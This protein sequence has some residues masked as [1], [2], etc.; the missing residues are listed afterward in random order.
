MA[1]AMLRGERTYKAIGILLETNCTDEIG[2]LI[3]GPLG[4]D[5]LWEAVGTAAVAVGGGSVLSR[6][7]ELRIYRR[8]LG[9][10]DG[11]VVAHA[12]L[13]LVVGVGLGVSCAT[14]EAHHLDDQGGAGGSIRG[15]GLGRAAMVVV[16][17][18]TADRT[19]GSGTVGSIGSRGGW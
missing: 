18:Q 19:A 8:G 5:G 9:V 14:V 4:D 13:V 7:R 6:R 11:G 10:G 12:S 2:T 3:H 16:M 1:L 17:P 15:G